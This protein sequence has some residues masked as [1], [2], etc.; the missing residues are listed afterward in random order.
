MI[1]EDMVE[2]AFLL[3]PNDSVAHSVSVMAKNK[4]YEAFVFDNEIMGIVSLDDIV[5]RRVTEPQKTK[6]SNFMKPI[7]LFPIDTP[8]EDIINY[9]LVS[10]YRS[11]PLEKSGVIYS[12]SKHKL[13]KFIKD[14]VFQ[15]RKAGD[16]V[17]FPY[18]ASNDD[19]VSTVISVM[20][21]AGIKRLVIF[22][23]KCKFTGI[24][25]SLSLVK[26]LID[27]RRSKRGERFG[28]RMKLGDMGVNSFVSREVM[29]VEPETELK[30]VVRKFS[31]KGAR[32]IIVEKNGKFLGIITIKDIFKLIGKSL[33]TVYVRVTGLDDE[34][35]FIKSKIDELVENTISK[36]LKITEVKYVAIHAE[37]QRKG[38]RRTMYSISGRIVTDRGSFHASDSE[39]DPTK[40]IKMLLGKIER[41]VHKRIEKLRGH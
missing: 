8:P 3:R 13:L 39:W 12:V 9:M 6:V 24:V 21:D 41:E 7:T 25:D 1:L 18:C 15:G 19:T 28:D 20:K 4:K 26:F 35:E 30:D 38:G 17:R 34:D 40:A 5:K 37:T 22:D 27:E 31:D 2:E 11:L 36:L 10:E 29:K 14:D 16:V 23:K 33:E 32:T